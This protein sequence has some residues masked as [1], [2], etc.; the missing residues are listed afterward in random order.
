MISLIESYNFGKI[1]FHVCKKNIE[2]IF[3]KYPT[4]H[5]VLELCYSFTRFYNSIVEQPQSSSTVISSIT[6]RW[7]Y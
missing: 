7:T 1:D 4:F 6:P 5:V 2:Q 3:I